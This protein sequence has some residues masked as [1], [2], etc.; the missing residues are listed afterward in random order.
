MSCK[1]YKILSVQN[2]CDIKILSV[3]D[4]TVLH[5]RALFAL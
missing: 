5:S 2:I 1:S 4:A 3:Q